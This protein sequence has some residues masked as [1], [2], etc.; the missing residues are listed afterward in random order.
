MLDEPRFEMVFELID[1]F[2]KTRTLVSKEWDLIGSEGELDRLMREIAYAL[3][4]AGYSKES[5]KG[6]MDVDI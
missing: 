1:H 4:G 5:I 2:T 3:Q 6:Y